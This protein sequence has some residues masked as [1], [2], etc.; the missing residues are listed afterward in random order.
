MQVTKRSARDGL[1]QLFP[2]ADARLILF[3]RLAK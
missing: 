2:Q 3:A 1:A